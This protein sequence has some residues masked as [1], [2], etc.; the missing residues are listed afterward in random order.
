[1]HDVLEL[2]MAGHA[3]IS[4]GNRLD[5]SGKRGVIGSKLG[6]IKGLQVRWPYQSGGRPPG[7]GGTC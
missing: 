2:G 1:V 4:L 5:V 6:Q 3:G 7:M